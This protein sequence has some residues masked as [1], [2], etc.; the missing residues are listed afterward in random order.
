LEFPQF[1]ETSVILTAADGRIFFVISKNGV[2][3]VGTTERVGGDPDTVMPTEEEINY[4]VSELNN[5]F[6]AGGFTAADATGMDAGIRPLAKP[7]FAK[8]AH[9]ISRE[10]K[11]VTTPDGVI[12]VLGVKLTD[13]RRAAQEL[14]DKLTKTK[15]RT[16]QTR[17]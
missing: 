9:E 8:S 5:Y 10:H 4:L 12:H 13:H 15:C 3:R 7:R 2:S 1:T 6:P 14:L 17:L 16:H 11:F